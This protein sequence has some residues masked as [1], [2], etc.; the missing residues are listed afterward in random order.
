[1]VMAQA[2]KAMITV[3]TCTYMRRTESFWAMSGGLHTRA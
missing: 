1:M 2:V 3:G